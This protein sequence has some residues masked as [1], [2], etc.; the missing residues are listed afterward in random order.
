MINFGWH[1][2]SKR[3]RERERRYVGKGDVVEKVVLTSRTRSSANEERAKK[4]RE[5]YMVSQVRDPC[6]STRGVVV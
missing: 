6:H 1:G 5:W 4:E 3:E 2:Y